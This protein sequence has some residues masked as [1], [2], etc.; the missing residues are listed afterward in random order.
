MVW[1]K[2]IWQVLQFGIMSRD[3]KMDQLK[4]LVS[5]MSETMFHIYI[6]WYSTFNRPLTECE[7]M[8]INIYKMMVWKAKTI[9]MLSNGIGILPTQ[10]EI[11]A[12][13]SNMY[14][15]LRSMYEMLFLFRCIYSSSRDDDERELL[16][17]IWKMRGNNN[18]KQIPK[19]ELDDELRN[20]KENAK[21]EN[22]T[23]LRDIHNL[24]NKL[25]LSPSIIGA[26]ELCINNS[27]PALKGFKFEHCDNCNAI[28]DFREMNFSDKEFNRVLAG[29]SY[30]Y[31]QFSAHSH[32]SFIGVKSF[33]DTYYKK[34][35]I[36]A[37]NTILE[38]TIR[39]LL[40]FLNEFCLYKDDY[41]QVFEEKRHRMAEIMNQLDDPVVK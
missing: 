5:E 30:R 23:L 36:R 12:N 18:L 10:K 29:A 7:N 4:L 39:F 25:S 15:V 19:D 16:L 20:K 1:Q 13:P 34:E 40:L 11:I 21:H 37:T 26:I 3:N 27:T 17:K 38:Q 31:T 22:K 24:E 41:R 32:P 28:I 14:P 33:E 35:E 9:L 8:A 2:Q 6:D